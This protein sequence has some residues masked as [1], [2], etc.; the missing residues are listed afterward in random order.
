MTTTAPDSPA[1]PNAGTEPAAPDDDDAALVAF[2]STRDAPCPLCGYNLHA[3]VEPRC[4]ECGRELVLSVGLAEP[5]LKAWITMTTALLLPAGIGV[6]F[7]LM[8]IRRGPPPPREGWVAVVI[9]FFIAHVPAA[10]VAVLYRRRFMKLSPQ[11]QWRWAWGAVA[12]SVL[13]FT[14]FLTKMR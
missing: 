9:F 8:I 10:A 12:A 3:L 5:M 1:V 6:L 11:A 7:L 13:A 4:P 14:M 2:L